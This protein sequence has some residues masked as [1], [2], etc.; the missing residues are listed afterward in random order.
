MSAWYIFTGLG[1]YPVNPASGDYMIGSPL[2]T[3][4]TLRLATGGRFTVVAQNN[5]ETK[6]YIQSAPLN[7]RPLTSPAVVS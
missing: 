2:F 1:F 6:R 3:R 7:G 4:A 5:S